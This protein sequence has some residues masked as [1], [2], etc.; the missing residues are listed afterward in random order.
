VRHILPALISL[1]LLLSG[2]SL[3]A[4]PA[5]HLYEHGAAETTVLSITPQNCAQSVDAHPNAMSTSRKG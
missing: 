3:N 1:W 4:M 5:G 2:V